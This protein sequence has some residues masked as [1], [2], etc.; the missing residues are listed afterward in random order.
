[1]I[2]SLLYKVKK[3]AKLKELRK[4]SQNC[5]SMKRS[6]AGA[7]P[8]LT[9]KKINSCNKIHKLENHSIEK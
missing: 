1:M 8:I 2:F 4:N 9:I 6:E 5:S 3:S 7:V